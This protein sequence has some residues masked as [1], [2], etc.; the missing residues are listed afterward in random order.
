MIHPAGKLLLPVTH[1]FSVKLRILCFPIV[2]VL[3]G[4][5]CK[6]SV[7]TPSLPVNTRPT[8]MDTLAATWGWYEDISNRYYPPRPAGYVNFLRFDSTGSFTFQEAST[9]PDVAHSESLKTDVG[10]AHTIGQFTVADT[11]LTLSECFHPHRA[12]SS[13]CT[14][15]FRF[16]LIPLDSNKNHEILRSLYIK[17]KLER[18]DSSLSF[19]SAQRKFD[20]YLLDR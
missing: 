15:R 2:L 10:K 16:E 7:N 12:D 18:L 19:G 8:T 1:G 3:I 4:A 20:Y 5:F 6:S 9:N 13:E 14:S 17:L 11:V